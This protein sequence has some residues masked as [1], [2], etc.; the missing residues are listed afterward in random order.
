VSHSP[1]ALAQDPGW[2]SHPRVA[3]SVDIRELQGYTQVGNRSIRPVTNSSSIT[4]RTIAHYRILEKIGGGGMGVVYKAEDTQLH[5]FVAMKFLSNRSESDPQ[6]LERFRREA[7]AT[8]A[9]NH[10]NI[11]TIH[12]IGE[13]NGQTYIVMELLEGQT[14]KH[15][16]ADGPVELATLLDLSI[17][18]A[19][20][21]DAAHAQGIVHRDIKSAN[22]F[23]TRR[24]HAKILDFGLAKV[25]P[26]GSGPA[27]KTELSS[28]ET[29]GV[30]A[31]HLTSPGTTLGTVAYMSP[32]QI[33][34]KELDTRTDLFSFGVVLYE[35]A[36]GKI[37]FRG[38]SP[39]VIMGA[40]L[41]RSPAAPARLNPDLPARLEDIITKCLEKE[42]ALRYQHASEICSDLK[43]LKRDTASRGEHPPDDKEP[44]VSEPAAATANPTSTRGKSPGSAVPGGEAKTAAPQ[45][46]KALAIGTAVIVFAG[47][48][49]AA[50]LYWKRSHKP[51]KLTDKDTIVLADF[52]NTTGEPVFDE[53]LK[54][55]LAI[56]LEQSPFLSLVSEQRI[57]QTLR[58]MGQPPDARLT[59]GMAR[60]LCQ[61]AEGAAEVDGSIARL[62][63][64]YVLALEA[65]NCS[66]GDILGREQ[67]T[68]E[69]KSHVLAALG[70]AC[71]SLR[72]KLGES[73]S[74]LQKY[75]TPVEQATTHS[76]EA[77]QAYSLGRKMTVVQGN[78]LA[79]V[80]LYQKAIRADA[81]FAMAYASLGTTY[82]NL[83]ESTLAEEN[84]RKSFELRDQVSEREKYYIES[85]YYHF[86]TGD[87]EE[88]RK[89]YELWAQAYP[90]EFIPA[91]N[92]G[93]IYRSL[94]DYEKSLSEAQ[95]RLR[96][97]PA[98][99]PANSNVVA[100][101]VSLNRLEEARDMYRRA[102]VRRLESA[103][104]KL[105]MYQLAFLQNDSAGMAEQATWFASK[106]EVEDALRAN[107]AETA[108]Y[109]GLLVKA[110]EL[111]RLA[112]T[113]AQNAKKRETAADHEAAAALREA[114]FGNAGEARR[115]AAAA[116][117]LSTGRNV[118]FGA[119]LALALTQTAIPAQRL[120][121]HMAKS[122]PENTVV[123]FNFLP[124]LRGQL[125][126]D[127]KN[128]KDAI[129]TLQKAA[130]YELGLPGDGSFTPALYPVYIRGEAYLASNRASE[131]AIEF[132]KILTWRG[133][134]VNEP[135]GALAHLGLGRA[136]ELQGDA[137][138]A[139][140][141][142]QK[143]LTLW[144]D[145]D[146]DIPLLRVA[147]SE[148]AKLR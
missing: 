27:A 111:S 25:S 89:V 12:A 5:R 37:P 135:I 58:M 38:E 88:A 129:E 72:S 62:G 143:F 126:L 146:P 118:E 100:A 120:A 87:L 45:L 130:P 86:V 106:P 23:V 76:L 34:A 142:Y 29:Q 114:L 19:D 57:R 91:N 48:I 46:R 83:G 7:E 32:E 113:L 49:I 92:L 75:D 80:P 9:L 97:D 55:G 74:T 26:V 11:C 84:T 139:R 123:Q 85:H 4:G 117:A 59:P 41:N 68:S 147:K 20:A 61:R 60:E 96:L 119:G 133:V 36:T 13:E 21:L 53:A 115:R 124:T 64:Q 99:A 42:R 43:R 141:A 116:L 67:V 136:F 137:T 14:L 35:M 108:A 18:I 128:A 131:A 132:Q 148:Y 39:G 16:I 134:V 1:V 140:A 24:G 79:A 112:V 50:G 31:E 69:D 63:S 52:G 102:E 122:F 33:R 6:V 47:G 54:Q 125:A 78:Y 93:I 17:Q 8:S 71:A 144:K 2:S 44:V 56:Q 127:R 109:S 10:P 70:K 121:E 110:R 40:I 73:L 107:E 103:F 30:T 101:Y 65:V 66:T 3:N 98:S 22:L 105:S 82:N 51:L 81:N 15:F 28:E 90:R 104:L 145:A 95:E 77:L 94:G 138:K